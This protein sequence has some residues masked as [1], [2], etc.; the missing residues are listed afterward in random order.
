[1]ASQV[2]NYS[3]ILQFANDLKLMFCVIHDITDFYQ[4]DIDGLVHTLGK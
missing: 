4:S 1:M 3:T 2:N